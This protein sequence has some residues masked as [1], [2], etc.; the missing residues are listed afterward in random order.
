[1]DKRDVSA[2]S[3]SS[4]CHSAICGAVKRAAA[5]CIALTIALSPVAIS[6]D[7]ATPY[8]FTLN[9]IQFFR[10][11]FSTDDW[12]LL[13]QYT[14][15]QYPQELTPASQQFDFRLYDVAT[16]QPVAS[17]NVY[18]YS[19]NGYGMGI[20][21]IYLNSANAPS[22]TDE[23]YLM[24]SGNP[25]YWQTTIIQVQYTVTN[26]NDSPGDQLQA[27]NT[28]IINQAKILEINWGIKM[29]EA[30][31]M[32][33]PVL[34]PTGQEYFTTTIPGLSLILSDSMGSMVIDPNWNQPS[35][36]T[37]AAVGWEELWNDT[38]FKNKL[39]EWGNIWGIAWNAISGA[40]LFLVMILCA[41]ISQSK[42]GNGDPGFY[43]GNII[44][45]TGT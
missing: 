35:Q 13:F 27:L 12:L 29:W 36:G 4:R 9:D 17:A 24:M 32:G 41:S 10:S 43:M 6:A 39:E 38:A 20:G 14:I 22:D 30:G 45:I 18:D 11:I 2:K 3:K 42:W 40:V 33:T 26:S 37:S 8:I 15:D 44:L 31:A 5:V 19:N 23:L 25:V 28:Y 7:P 16:N 1:M 34:T 21:S